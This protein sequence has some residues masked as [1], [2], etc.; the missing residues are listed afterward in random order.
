MV[1]CWKTP[2]PAS[3]FAKIAIE[4]W[5]FP[6]FFLEI[7]VLHGGLEEYKWT[8]WRQTRIHAI[9]HHSSNDVDGLGQGQGQGFK[10]ILMGGVANWAFWCVNLVPPFSIEQL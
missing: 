5:Y 8:K 9:T 7:V 10:N 1:L 3:Y 4:Y 2:K 6:R